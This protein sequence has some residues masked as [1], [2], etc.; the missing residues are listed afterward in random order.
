MMSIKIEIEIEMFCLQEV[1]STKNVLSSFHSKKEGSNE[2]VPGSETEQDE[3]KQYE[4]KQSS[5]NR[6]KNEE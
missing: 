5:M 4:D 2:N 1:V 3:I 6:V